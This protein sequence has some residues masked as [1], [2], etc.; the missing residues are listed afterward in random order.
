MDVLLPE[1]G[2]GIIDV[3]IRDVLVKNGD[4]ITKN[5]TILI[6]ETDKAS[7]EIPSEVDGVVSE[8]HVKKGDIISPNDKI[9][10][11]KENASIKDTDETNL[12]DEDTEE[13]IEKIE[14]NMELQNIKS[15]K[16]DINKSIN[17]LASPSIRKLSREL[18][19]DIKLINGS[20]DKGRITKEDI[21][22]YVNRN[23]SSEN[24]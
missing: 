2:E 5:Q 21:L 16:Q 6:L 9:I 22:S 10:S 7:M 17:I 8:I 19:C 4:S 14:K 20:G 13:E 12:T 23:L 11:L 3:E 1:L 18:G 24:K 15:D